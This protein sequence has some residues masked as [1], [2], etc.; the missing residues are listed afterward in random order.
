MVHR[1]KMAK[2]A[3]MFKLGTSS[4]TINEEEILCTKV[5]IYCSLTQEMI[6]K[7]ARGDLH[8]EAVLRTAFKIPNVSEGPVTHPDWLLLYKKTIED[9]KRAGQRVIMKMHLVSMNVF[10][11]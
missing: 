10:H 1:E 8:K 4:T 11:L 3:S 6:T 2:L 7:L 5:S 9:K